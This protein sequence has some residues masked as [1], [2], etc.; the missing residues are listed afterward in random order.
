MLRAVNIV[1]A[2][3]CLCIAAMAASP[4][5]RQQHEQARCLPR[6]VPKAL[7]DAVSEL[8]HVPARSSYK[9]HQDALQH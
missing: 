3:L 4:Q 1:V 2:L 9:L 8:A 7:L 5:P 6:Q